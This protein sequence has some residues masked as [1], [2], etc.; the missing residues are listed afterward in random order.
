LRAAGPA[1]A[2]VT[3]GA[4][5]CIAAGPDGVHRHAALQVCAVDSSGAGDTF[6]G[7]L[8]ALLASGSQAAPAI[9]AAQQAAALTVARPGAYAALP[10]A[11]ELRS[12][13]GVRHPA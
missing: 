5:G 9:A 2:I 8:A 13:A 1:L 4:A 6:C 10:S 11:A 7:V 12:L 3:L